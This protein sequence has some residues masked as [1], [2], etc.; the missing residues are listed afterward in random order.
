M[1]AVCSGKRPQTSDQEDIGPAPV[2]KGSRVS[3]A[4]DVQCIEVDDMRSDFVQVEDH[5]NAVTS[6]VPIAGE[7]THKLPEKYPEENEKK[8]KEEKTTKKREPTPRAVTLITTAVEAEPAEI[9]IFDA[10]KVV[11]EKRTPDSSSP[12]NFAEDLKEDMK[13]KRD[14][15]KR[16]RAPSIP[17][18]M[19]APPPDSVLQ[20]EEFKPSSVR[21]TQ[22]HERPSSTRSD[23]SEF[24]SVGEMFAAELD[25]KMLSIDVKERG[26]EE[27]MESVPTP[28]N[29]PQLTEQV[30]QVYVGDDVPPTQNEAEI[31]ELFADLGDDNAAVL[32]FSEDLSDDDDGGDDNAAV[33]LFSEDLRDD[34]IPADNAAVLFAEEVKEDIPAEK[35]SKVDAEAE[36]EV[37]VVAVAEDS[38]AKAVEVEKEPEEPSP[39]AENEPEPEVTTTE[40]DETTV[41]APPQKEE[42]EEEDVF[43][44]DEPDESAEAQVV[45][46]ISRNSTTT[47]I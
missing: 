26:S 5:V 25:E 13:K 46:N 24:D 12:K 33:I 47:G 11:S 35:A 31:A 6:A 45:V 23:I 27:N 42:E 21:S 38:S 4:V 1:G 22:Q 18:S 29:S 36:E 9:Q 30:N 15:A 7:R 37:I 16:E 40:P 43:E 14:P 3:S 20:E 28:F 2:R 34:D 8:E 41:K 44:F 19:P 10:T 32:L 17:A 39:P